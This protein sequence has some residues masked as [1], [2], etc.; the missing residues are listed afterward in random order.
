MELCG[1]TSLRLERKEG[2]PDGPRVV[3]LERG[4]IRMV[5][6]PRLGEERIEIHTPAAIA[7]LLGTVVHVSVD[8]LGVTTITSAASQVLVKHSDPSIPGSVTIDGGEQVVMA[9]GQA[10]PLRGTRVSPRMM[11]SKGGC[12]ID[13]HQVAL[14]ADRTTQENQKV[15]EVVSEDIVD[16]LPPVAAAPEPPGTFE[17]AI[18]DLQS[19]IN[20]PDTDPPYDQS[21]SD[22]MRYEYPGGQEPFPP[23]D[24]H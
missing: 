6:E 5:V 18:N 9:P 20:D 13:F 2:R 8:A 19:D 11:A 10:T 12:L 16:E 24:V 4:E 14:G 23:A 21:D 3:K 1:D 15:E 22:T 17:N 7:T